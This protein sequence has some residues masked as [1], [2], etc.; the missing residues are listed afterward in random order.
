MSR[1]TN[2]PKSYGARSGFSN[3]LASSRNC[4]RSLIFTHTRCDGYTSFCCAL[5]SSCH[6]CSQLRNRTYKAYSPVLMMVHPPKKTSSNCHWPAASISRCLTT[7][8]ADQPVPYKSLLSHQCLSNPQNV[9][10]N[11]QN[12]NQCAKSQSTCVHPLIT[13]APRMMPTHPATPIRSISKSHSASRSMVTTTWSS[14]TSE[15][16]HSTHHHQ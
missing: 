6:C 13:H 12:R 7:T 10:E 5:M 3:T 1:I 9:D 16:N 14:A 8:K 15:A 11:D 4:Y 2:P